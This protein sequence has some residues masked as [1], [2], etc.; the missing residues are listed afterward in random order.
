MRVLLIGGT[1]VLGREAVPRLLAAGH[2]V[3][4]LAR[5]DE[6]ATA[7]RALG[8]EPVVADLF[9]PDSMTKAVAG[10]EAVVNLATRIPTRPAAMLRGMTENDRIRTEGS[11]ALVD[12]ALAT[13]DVR[14][15]VQE[16][17]S[18]VYADGGDD[19]LTEDARLDPVGPVRS[20]LT[21]HAN[22]ARFAES[23]GAGV[24]LRIAALI[25]D[26]PMA[27]LLLRLGRMR[28]PVMFG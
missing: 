14:V 23:G 25:G 15:I 20:S 19:V 12:A 27:R 26:E 13:G 28:L 10:H 3:T 18:F 24:R 6:R 4:G 7:V 9:D 22:V 11:R 1:G 8:I 2:T 5:S 17:V 16:G 21:A